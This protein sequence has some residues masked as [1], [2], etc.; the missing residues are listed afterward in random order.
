MSKKLFTLLVF[1]V[2]GLFFPLA[3]VSAQNLAT[4]ISPA[5]EATNVDPET[6]FL[7]KPSFQGQAYRLDIGSAAG[8]NDVY[9]SGILSWNTAAISSVPGLLPITKY[10]IRLWTELRG[11]WGSNYVDSTFTTGIGTAHLTYPMPNATN[12]D[13]FAPFT[14]NSI[15]SAVSYTLDIGSFTGG[16]NIFSSRA[17]TATSIVVTG[18]RSN[19]TYHARLF[20]QTS[21]GSTESDSTFT[22]G[23]GLAHLIQPANGAIN[24]DPGA[25]F[26][27]NSVSN[28]Q[29]YSLGIGTSVGAQDVWS[30]GSV[31]S[32]HLNVPHLAT[33][34]L[35]YAHLG[36]RKSNTWYYVDTTF[37]TGLATAA[38]TYPV[39]GAT[40]VDPWAPFTW[41]TV[42]DAQFYLLW[43][44]K[45]E[46]DSSIYR[47]GF[48]QTTSQ[49]VSGLH[50]N[51][52]YWARLFTETSHGSSYTDST[53]TTGLGLAHLITPAD[54][55]SSVD[56]FQPFAWNS[57][58][59]AQGYYIYVGTTP[60]ATD[61]YN[62][63]AL[64]PSYTSWFVPGL[65][66][67]QTYYVT[68][69]TQLNNAWT[70]VASSF[71]TAPQSLP[72]S[73]NAFRNTV[74]QQTGLVRLMTQG[75]TN[76]PTPG[77]LLAQVVAQG[78]VST[79]A[80][81]QDYTRTLV[82]QLA[83]QRITA[84][85]RNIGF[86]GNSYDSHIVTEYYDPFLNY[87]IVADP[88]FAVVYWNPSNA[89]GMSVADLNS[90]VVGQ[91]WSTITPF[92]MYA[93][94]NGEVYAHNYYMD[95]I[96]LYL[97]P[98]PVG[99]LNPLQPVA[100]SPAPYLQVHNAAAVG[101]QGIWVF[102]FQNQTD[103]ATLSDPVFGTLTA[104]PLGGTPYSQGIFLDA[105]WSVV[106]APVGV[107]TLTMNRYV[108]F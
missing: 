62:S 72:S 15:P 96:L 87:W 8:Q 71:S 93:T 88:T 60:G 37:T 69:W 22:T 50:Q 12:V 2:A 36:T 27:W 40:N 20:T 28:A 106:S 18:L 91:A 17:I 11:N 44:G 64:V 70:A 29:A 102:G 56:P 16:S 86:D 5:N 38:L 99:D 31:Q 45:S 1:A 83:T 25:S 100:N 35:Y 10:Y 104:A 3:R 84:R 77:T 23:T 74:K 24:V 49:T 19:T 85:I 34:T 30:S 54:Q 92:I 75:V 78:G 80:F 105:G 26:I 65:L 63:A 42:S 103:T 107:Q 33:N 14:W 48:L 7:W 58:P 73:A 67:G 39:N 9:D 66:G 79:L 94:S 108:Y 47:S 32:T 55:A 76:T 21:Q 57:V 53:F 81:C 13:Q 95:P 59:G 97:N 98:S 89:T 41:T 6:S 51:T 90:A 4:M 82:L 101:T 61:I 52:T 43:I 68:L 46:G